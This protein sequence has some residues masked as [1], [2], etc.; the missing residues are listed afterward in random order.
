M[1]RV[2]GGVVTIAVATRQG[3]ETQDEKLVTLITVTLFCNGLVWLAS[4]VAL[5]R[6]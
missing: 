1:T 4:R 3:R 5:R 6:P 2:L